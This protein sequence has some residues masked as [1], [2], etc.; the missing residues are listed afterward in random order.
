MGDSVGVK[1]RAMLLEHLSQFDYLEKVIIES[2]EQSL[3]RLDV[4]IGGHTYYVNESPGKSLTRRSIADIQSLLTP[5]II[6]KM[7]LRQVSP[8]DEMM[9]QDI[10]PSSNELLVPLG[11]FFDDLIIE[12]RKS[13]QH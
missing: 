2:L 5:Y 10:S 6:H 4:V 12:Q 1:K 3:Y 7:Y 11:N 8:Y 13:I 9:G